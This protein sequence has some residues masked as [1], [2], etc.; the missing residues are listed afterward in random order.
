[1]GAWGTSLYKND[2][3]SDI[4]GDYVDL[5]RRGKT[6]EDVTQ[7][8]LEEYRGVI[9]DIE[10]EPL[11][12]FALADT[13]WNYGRLLPEVKEKALAFLSQ[14][15]ELERWKDSGE[16][17]LK[18]WENTLDRLKEK[19]L[20]PQPPEK[21]IS[22]YR[23]YQCKWQL[24]DV[25]SYRFSSEYSKEKGVYGQ[26]II[27]RKVSED[28][29]WPGHI[30]PVVQVYKWIGKDITSIGSLSNMSLLEQ[31]FYPDALQRNP[32]LPKEFNIKLLSTSQK[33][34]PK[35]NLCFLG[36][37]PGDDLIPFRGP[38]YWTGYTELGWNSQK[39]NNTFEN[40]IIDMY[41]AWK[42]HN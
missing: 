20:S 6:N 41:L 11:F 29:W 30:V 25:F 15:Y 1:M 33:V 19:L 9:G 38:N 40:Y 39:Y 26:Y 2:T 4:C 14:N 35:D 17:Q 27:F 7:E 42:D 13:Q 8:L 24:G 34:I 18:E 10:E 3:A 5:L 31:G 21:K 12:W 37:I 28:V 16:K 32:H 36:N 23:L 22:K